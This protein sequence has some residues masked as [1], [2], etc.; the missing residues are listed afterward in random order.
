MNEQNVGIQGLKGVKLPEGLYIIGEYRG[1]EE[2]T[3]NNGTTYYKLKVLNGDYMQKYDIKPEMS[4]ELKNVPSGKTII[5]R[6][7]QFPSKFDRNIM[8]T[9]CN[10]FVVQ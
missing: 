9:I 10:E 6:Y 5:V 4:G 8:N 1:V 2:K 3:G 7:Y